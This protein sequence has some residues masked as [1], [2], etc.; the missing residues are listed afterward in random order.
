VKFQ[1]YLKDVLSLLN[2]NPKVVKFDMVEWDEDD[3]FDEEKEL[4]EDYCFT[5]PQ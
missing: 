5:I 1:N 2:K 3:V 4:F